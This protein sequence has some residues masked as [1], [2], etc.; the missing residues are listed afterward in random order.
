MSGMS[1]GELVTARGREWVVQP[2]TDPEVLVLKPLGGTEEETTRIFLPLQ[3]EEDRVAPYDFQPPTADDLG[4]LASSLLLYDASRLSFRSGAGPFR[5]FGRLSFRPR[6]YQLVPMIMALRQ[7]TIRLMIADDV[8]IGKT[9]E[10]GMIM[11]E[12]LDRGE[13]DRFAVL[14]LPHLC[15][16]WQSELRDK[17]GIEAVVI[18]SGTISQLERQLP[19][20]DANIYQHFPFQ[21]ISIDFAKGDH[22]R[23]R[24]L[25][26]CPDHIIVD[27][28]HTCANSGGK[29]RS[30]QQ[31]RHKLLRDLAADPRKHLVLLTA[32][33]HSGKEDEFNSLLG[34]LD[35]KFAAQGF[36]L[37]S[38]EQ[39]QAVADHFI[40]RRRKDIEKYIKEK[41]FPGR[42]S[43]EV[44]YELSDDY[45]ELFARVIGFARELVKD[46][47][48][49][50]Y[51]QRYKYWAALGLLRGAMSSPDAGIEMLR[52]RAFNVDEDS[53]SQV[54]TETEAED[55]DNP[56]ND[57]DTPED[58]DHTPSEVMGKLTFTE[59]EVKRLHSLAKELEA[60]AHSAKDHKA[61]KALAVVRE[62]LKDKQGVHPIIFCRYIATAKYLG[63]YLKCHLGNE[64]KGLQVEVITGGDM[65][66]DQRKE[67]ID[68]I[69]AK[70]PR[71]VVCTDCLSEGINLQEKFN[72]VMHYDLPWNPNRLEQREGRVDRFGQDPTRDVKAYLLYGQDNPIDGVVLKV[73]L[74]KAREIRERI[75]ISVPFPEDSRTVTDAVMKAVLLN[76]QY[77]SGGVQG[78]LFADDPT[79]KQ[80]EVK[81]ERAFAKARDEQE[82]TRN[83]FAQ[84]EVVKTLDIEEDLRHT[85]AVLGNPEAVEALVTQAVRWLGGQLDSFKKG[86]KLFPQ[87]LPEAVK[88]DFRKQ[89]EVLISFRSPTP[90]GYRY[91]GR[92]HPFVEGL[93]DYLLA[94]AFEERDGHRLPRASVFRTARVKTRHVVVQFRLRNVISTG[95]G[96]PDI[97][98]EEVL[99]W[100]W[101]DDG[102]KRVFLNADEAHELLTNTTVAAD[103]HTEQQA[104]ALTAGI[105]DLKELQDTVTGLARDRS[106]ELVKAHERYRKAL[107]TKRY[108]VGTIVPPDELGLYIFYPALG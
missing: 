22:R 60:I 41:V 28:A 27:E 56:V 20:A 67:A 75:G 17:F 29:E 47:G 21:I 54:F 24:F 46:D 6:S 18:R 107:G 57:G 30:A 98:A 106:Q 45:H 37:D 19:S 73:L 35:K 104:E 25:E 80:E 48:S 74:R 93:C 31:Q 101:R 96:A 2:S 43:R 87:Q 13:L 77:N 103:M 61:A 70:K 72:A 90:E 68:A 11:R 59:S 5:S 44:P 82:R 38:K 55:T 94:C 83:L 26:H 102:S 105:A 95:N 39:V 86:F 50:T 92:N 36:S 91:I 53:A 81:V 63:E 97:V 33:P 78:D 10:A 12:L 7:Q 49:P 108:Q 65:N 40:Q 84:I 9:I 34:L 52:T 69:D 100:G 64:V 4:D 3:F 89:R 79:V 1:P 85:D 76:P 99:R 16:Q 62:W 14:C 71:I 8:G 88:G 32:T 51:R 15:E 42:E 66:D 23:D 58:N